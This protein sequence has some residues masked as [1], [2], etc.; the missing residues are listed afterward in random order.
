MPESQNKQ[1]LTL[2]STQI[3]QFLVCPQLWSYSSRENLTLY[4]PGEK[5]EA[6]LMG[7][8]GHAILDI[9]Y[10]NM[11]S[12][13]NHAAALQAGFS[14]D[15]DVVTCTCGHA[16]TAHSLKEDL[17]INFLGIMCSTD[18]CNCT[19]FIPQPFNLSTQNRALVKNRIR[20]YAYKW[21]GNDIM[22]DS[23]ESV[24][25]G[26]S[27]KLYEDDLRLYILEGRIDI[28]GSIQGLSCIVDHKF[29]LRAHQLY[30]KS[31]QFRNYSLVTRKPMLVVN[32]IRLAKTITEDTLSRDIISFSP[33]EWQWWQGQL[34]NIYDRILASKQNGTYGQNFSACRGQYGYPCEFTQLCECSYNPTLVELKK[35]A[36]KQKEPWRPW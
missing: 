27:H 25:V 19:N 14:Y 15:P 18:K 28:L 12:G 22:P 34:V 30:Q 21:L 6:M 17:A 23:P 11:A 36:Y 7:T 4:E 26:F 20:D 13:M 9:F 24:E 3:E 35:S 1:V 29:Q 8:Y 33:I 10:K 5:K 31:V 16:K 2:D 32:Y